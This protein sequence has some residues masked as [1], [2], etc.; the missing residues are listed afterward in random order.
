MTPFTITLVLS[1]RLHDAFLVR[2][3]LRNSGGEAAGNKR[4]YITTPPL[5]KTSPRSAART[6]GWNFRPQPCGLTRPR[7]CAIP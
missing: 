2:P 7:A 6:P 4:C 3:R 1:R 5:A